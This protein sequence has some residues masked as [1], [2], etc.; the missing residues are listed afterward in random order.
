MASAMAGSCLLQSW[1]P[2]ENTR[3]RSPSR[4]QI[5]RKPSC[6]ISWTGVGRVLTHCMVII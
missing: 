5:K 3:T 6:L 4:L 2:R 1:P